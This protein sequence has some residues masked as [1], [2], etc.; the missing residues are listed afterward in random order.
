MTASDHFQDL[1]QLFQPGVST[2]EGLWTIFFKRSQWDILCTQ[3]HY[4]S[5][6]RVSDGGC[7]V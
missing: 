2:S 3:P 1:K 4:V 5:F 7:W 6:I